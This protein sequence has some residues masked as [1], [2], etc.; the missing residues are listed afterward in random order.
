VD[1]T[2]YWLTLGQEFSRSGVSIRTAR[3][4]VC[5]NLRFGLRYHPPDFRG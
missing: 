3:G 1:P 2:F 5:D 4:K